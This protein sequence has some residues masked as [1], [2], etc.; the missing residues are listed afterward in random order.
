MNS[1]EKCL[2][3]APADGERGSLVLATLAA[4]ARKTARTRFIAPGLP[5]AILLAA[6]SARA[7]PSSTAQPSSASV[8]SISEPTEAAR[9]S[10]SETAGTAKDGDGD[11]TGGAYTTPTLL[12]VPAAAVPAGTVRVITSLDMQGPTAEDRLASGTS[13]GFQPGLGGEV[14][15]PA[16]FTIGAGTNWAG[17]DTSPT[18]L[19]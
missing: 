7:Q 19:S 10:P 6:S 8:E 13:L 16:G 15:L 2:G 17:G 9:T 12:F 18:P 1:I 11:P 4:I 5:L 14:G 3:L